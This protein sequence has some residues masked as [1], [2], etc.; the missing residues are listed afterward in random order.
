[1]ASGTP[2]NRR[3]RPGGAGRSG[4][5][6]VGSCRSW[7]TTYGL[8]LREGQVTFP[9]TFRQPSRSSDATVAGPAL[10]PRRRTG[11]SP[12]HRRQLRVYGQAA[13]PVER[14]NLVG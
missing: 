2:D 6:W 9:S 13:E 8:T 3:G 14:V 4:V 5:E 10:D 11:L 1:P 7:A 12:V